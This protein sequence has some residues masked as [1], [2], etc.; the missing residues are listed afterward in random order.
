MVARCSK[1][2]KELVVPTLFPTRAFWSKSKPENFQPQV[3]SICLGEGVAKGGKRLRGCEFHQ[4]C[5]MVYMLYIYDAPLH[6]S[7]GRQEHLH[8]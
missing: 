6:S 8:F 2:T 7:S 3:K 5:F 4:D 1:T